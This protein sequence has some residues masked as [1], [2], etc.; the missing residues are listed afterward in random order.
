VLLD[1]EKQEE[2]KEKREQEREAEE[3][4]EEVSELMPGKEV[5]EKES[6]KEKDNE[7]KQERR[8]R[9]E[10]EAEK[11]KEAKEEREEVPKPGRKKEIGE[12]AKRKE[13]ENGV[14]GSNEV[15]KKLVG[16]EREV[17]QE[18]GK[19]REKRR[20]RE[21]EEEKREAKELLAAEKSEREETEGERER[22]SIEEAPSKSPRESQR[23]GIGD[24]ERKKERKKE[25]LDEERERGS[26]WSHQLEDTEDQEAE[27][28]FDQTCVP[29]VAQ[30]KQ[31]EREEIR[32][33]LRAKV[34]EN[35]NLNA[36]EKE[37]LLKLLLKHEK[38]FV[39]RLEYPGQLQVDGEPVVHVIKL[40]ED[41]TPQ[42]Q[43]RRREREDDKRWKKEY[44]EKLSEQGIIKFGS[45]S[46]WAMN[47]VIV[48][49]NGQRRLA[50]DAT[51]INK[52]TE[53][54]PYPMPIVVDILEKVAGA[55]WT[56][57]IDAVR[58]YW[59][60]KLAEESQ[61]ITATLVAEGKA[62]WLVMPFGLKNAGATFQRA[63]DK[64]F[65]NFSPD[66]I[67]IYV[68]DITPFTLPSEGGEEKNERG[69][70]KDVA[71]HLELLERVF[72][73]AGESNLMV[74]IDKCNFF[75]KKAKLL[76]FMAGEGKIAKIEKSVAP[77]KEYPVPKSR[78]QLERF[79]GMANF[80]RRFV[81]N[82]ALF[83][84][85]LYKIAKLR[86]WGKERV[87]SPARRSFPENQRRV[88]ESGGTINPR[89]EQRIL[90]ESRHVRRWA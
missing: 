26:E 29:D 20:D 53:S 18:R 4:R 73:R 35:E 86:K 83:A 75:S 46:E 39:R 27:D 15:E 3:E 61:P 43:A 63:M 62:V 47:T 65:E 25:K 78:V 52:C 50:V 16:S 60:I 68:D 76:G 19:G 28:P 89:L 5:R 24:K 23:E 82:F 57:P 85:P 67:V 10:R 72:Q 11:E 37:E 59:Q 79:L 81:R 7:R 6:E 49:K 56:S 32:N 55:V 33:V 31:R 36:R 42:A 2:M 54:D 9:K 14:S 74:K 84:E 17:V 71:E 88:V 40:K 87:A 41:A 38:I 1:G 66:E 21:E 80:Y 90:S 8:A 64:I 30:S 69:V 13:K 70:R 58:G 51:S 44:M 12:K 45:R 34:D 48:K 22:E 77:I